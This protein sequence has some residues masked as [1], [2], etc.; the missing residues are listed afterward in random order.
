MSDETQ[1]KFELVDLAAYRS[2]HSDKATDWTPLDALK[3]V[4]EKIESGEWPVS[5]IYVACAWGEEDG[6]LAR[7][8]ACAGC[9]SSMETLGL[10]AQHM[11]DRGGPDAS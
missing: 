9:R 8:H 3:Q 4:I 11:Y 6:T 1:P 7:S 5:Q 10:L 2:E